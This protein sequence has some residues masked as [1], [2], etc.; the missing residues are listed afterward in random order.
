MPL[1]RIITRNPQDTID[2]SEYLRSLGY[3]VETVSPGEFR[4]TPAEFEINLDK[5]PSEKALERAKALL[6]ARLGKVAAPEVA[7]Q[8]QPQKPKI[9][10]AYDIVGRPVE[11]A[12]EEEPAPDRRQKPNSATTALVSMFARAKQAIGAGIMGAG[13]SL[14]TRLHNF[15]HDRAE[16]RALKLE[17]ELAQEREEIRH[18]EELARERVRQEIERQRW[19][20]ELAE[21]HRQEQIEAEKAAD[22]HR[23]IAADKVAAEQRERERIEAERAATLAAQREHARIDAERQ[24]EQERFAT[25]EERARV[26]AQ[27][28][29]LM[30]TERQAAQ[31]PTTEQPLTPQSP[32]Q[33][34]SVAAEDPLSRVPSP[35][36]RTPVRKPQ[37]LAEA[38]HWPPQGAQFS[39][40]RLV[41]HRRGP[42]SIS[43]KA[44]AAGLGA[45]FVL[46]LGFIAYAN[47]RPASPLTPWDLLHNHSIRQEV[48]FGAATI[49]GAPVAARPA[50]PAVKRPTTKASPAVRSSPRKPA[51]QRTARRLRQSSQND[52][53]AEDEVVVRHFQAAQ[54]K[55]QS[56]PSTAKL[57]HYSDAE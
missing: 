40:P 44:V 36:Q 20:G 19:E 54:P 18:E 39:L 22:E 52:S 23:R 14:R 42:I 46:L 47:R 30:E 11:F 10:I 15:Q 56:A 50:A 24:S 48:P 27:H 49:P 31:Q 38:L 35:V 26:A 6:E 4:V 13:Q 7:N 41:R 1:A 2:A 43:G 25:E 8:P 33:V 51:N 5:C 3:T 37:S 16:Q 17:A 21:R 9:P 55:P 34:A 53:L 45:S 57:K 28:E 12:D 32:K 29:A